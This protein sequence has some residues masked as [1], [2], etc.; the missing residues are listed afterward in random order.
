MCLV[1]DQPVIGITKPGSNIKKSYLRCE[2]TLQLHKPQS[3]AHLSD[4]KIAQTCLSPWHLLILA[5]F[6]VHGPPCCTLPT[7]KKTRPAAAGHYIKKN[8]FS[9][10]L[11]KPGSCIRNSLRCEQKRCSFTNHSQQLHSIHTCQTWHLL[12]LTFMVPAL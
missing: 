4:Y 8:N 10:I 2:L 7:L 1:G 12:I 11:T 9:R 5:Y 3:T 6:M